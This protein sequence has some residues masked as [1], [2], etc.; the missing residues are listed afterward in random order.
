MGRYINKKTVIDTDTGEI[1]KET[2][3]IGYD[4]FTDKGYQYRRRQ[5]CIRYFFDT[6]PDNLSENAWQILMM[7][8]EIMN[9]ENL[10]I[11]KV[12]R[13]SKFSEIIYKPYD[14]ED[15]R[16]RLRYKVGKN[17]FDK[18]WLELNKHC[19]KRIKYKDYMVWAVNPAIINKCKDIPLWLCEEF[20]SY[21]LPHLSAN[22][23]RK[24]E[25]KI[26]NQY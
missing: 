25:E 1:I 9:E 7:I 12:K 17:K 11:Y 14:K 8:A 15:I 13:K 16:E 22:T 6:L 19:L 24:L 23:A 20:K 3:W 21:M 26:N 4:G 2:N 5:T 18:C 10:L